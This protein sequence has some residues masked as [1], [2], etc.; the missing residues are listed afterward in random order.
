MAAQDKVN[1]N[2]NQN[3]WGLVV[4][5]AALGAAE[6]WNLKSLVCPALIFAWALSVL[7]LVSNVFYTWE[8]CL[9]KCVKAKRWLRLK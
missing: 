9:R 4:A 6:H 1:I 5:F 7:V 2:L 3:L 8:Y